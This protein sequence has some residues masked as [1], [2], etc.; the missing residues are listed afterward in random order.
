MPQSASVGKLFSLHN[1]K[2][3][4]KRVKRSCNNS[5]REDVHN[6]WRQP[7][8]TQKE[9]GGGMLGGIGCESHQESRTL[10]LSLQENEAEN[11]RAEGPFV[12]KF[13]LNFETPEWR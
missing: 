1:F 5:T 8:K 2:D 13:V 9:A 6:N 7:G 10:A 4:K 11:R 3:R 12:W